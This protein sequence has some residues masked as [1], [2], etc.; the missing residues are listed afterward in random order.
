MANE[1]EKNSIDYGQ[2]NPI[3]KP[4]ISRKRNVRSFSNLDFMGAVRESTYNSLYGI[5]ALENTGPYRAICLKIIKGT[6]ASSRKN[7]WLPSDLNVG[8]NTVS[9]RARIPEIHAYIP[10]PLLEP[11]EAKRRL[12]IEMHPIFTGDINIS[13]E[14]PGFSDLVMVDFVDKQNFREGLYISRIQKGMAQNISVPLSIQSVDY[15]NMYASDFPTA[16]AIQQPFGDSIGRNKNRLNSIG[17][18]KTLEEN[19]KLNFVANSKNVNELGGTTNFKVEDLRCK[20]HGTVGKGIEAG[21]VTD[22]Q[23]R[24]LRQTAQFLEISRNFW[25]TLFSDAELI[26]TSVLRPLNGSS[27]H[28][29]GL[30]VDVAVRTKFAK[31]WPGTKKD[32]LPVNIVYVGYRYMIEKGILPPGALGIYINVFGWRESHPFTT[33]V[34]AG[35]GNSKRG[36]ESRV[37]LAGS[38]NVH[39]DWRGSEKYGSLGLP[40]KNPKRRDRPEQMARWCWLDLDGNGGD[41]IKAYT[42]SQAKKAEI[43]TIYP[44]IFEFVWGDGWKAYARSMGLRGI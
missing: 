29:L 26:V 2:L 18:V 39:Y 27:M 42:K 31:N 43:D 24:N 20:G 21:V 3:S 15:K 14:E 23:I 16:A 34:S 38:A 9:I 17:N 37:G 25:R 11:N 12:L 13:S 32:V 36:D 4:N 1:D 6:P 41:E 5:D 8:S 10:D 40:S 35:K 19:S 22:R 33:F 44:S 28:G 30:A 7:N